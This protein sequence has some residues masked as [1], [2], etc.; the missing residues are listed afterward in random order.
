MKKFM[1]KVNTKIASAKVAIENK[2]AE[3]YVDTAVKILIADRCC[4]RCSSSGYAHSSFPE[5]C[6]ACYS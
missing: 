3:A 2:K 5:R 1:D 4:Y 6:K